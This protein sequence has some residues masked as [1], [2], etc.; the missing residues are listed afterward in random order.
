MKI[1]FI[2]N[3]HLNLYK[4]IEQ[5]F[6]NQGH[7]VTLVLDRLLRF[8]PYNSDAKCRKLKELVFVKICN[9][10]SCYW[11]FMIRKDKRLSD[12]YD[13]L[14]VL[15]GV[16]I[17]EYLIKYLECINPQLKKI[18]YTWDSCNYYNY[19]R[20]LQWFD[21]C[22][23]FDI[24][25]VEND[26]RWNLM[27]IYYK[28]SENDNNPTLIYDLF[29]IGT[30]HDERYN[31]FRQIIPQIQ[32]AGLKYYIKIVE[33]IQKVAFMQMLKYYIVR[34]LFHKHYSSFIDQI[35]FI[36]ENDVWN[37]KRLNLMTN[38]EYMQYSRASRCV[39]D[40]Q[41]EGQGGLT[42]RF[43]WGL[44]NGKK[45]VTTNKWAYYYSFVNPHQVFIIDRKNI[46]IPTNFIKSPLGVSDLA[47]VSF[48]QIDNWVRKILS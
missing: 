10:Y 26:S 48:L 22:Y 36:L 16:S 43:I 7:E 24:L 19:T 33:P 32:K 14:F 18:L 3:P 23:S 42:A 12:S 35:H 4:D 28:T 6:R 11:K 38:N 40:T 45:I 15:S 39:F 44:A 5:E 17:G 34:L 8:D 37:L 30:N 29:C 21:K 46:Q 47:D 27:P 2:A 41:R 25:D 31:L 9:I 13:I 1:L 20:L